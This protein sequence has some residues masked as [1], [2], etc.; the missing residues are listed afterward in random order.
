M[1]SGS[2]RAAAKGSYAVD[3]VCVSANG[4][5]SSSEFYIKFP[6]AAPP[7]GE[8]G[9]G[10]E[11]AVSFTSNGS[12]SGQIRAV[13][14]PDSD[15]T[16]YFAGFD[17]ELTHFAPSDVLGAFNLRKG[18]NMATCGN[19]SLGFVEF[20]IFLWEATSRIVVVDVDG[21]LTKSN[22]RGYLE[23]V[24]LATYGYIH[25]GVVLFLLFLDNLGLQILYLTARPRSHVQETRELL[26]NM[27]ENGM[28][29]PAGP[30]F[31][32]RGGRMTTLYMELIAESTATFKHSVL[33]DISA[34]YRRVAAAALPGKY[35][36][37]LYIPF[38]K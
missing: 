31:T 17:D 13:I 2:A 29:L 14:R 36:S 30:L 6:A 8:R 5:I 38:P 27:T 33:T 10:A 24:F 20:S 12:P 9:R 7:P 28:Y 22:V 3:V 18:R 23:T 35:I 19:S 26:C 15:K 37:L 34:V 25:V 21:T 4:C 32:H 16:V 11:V 1:F